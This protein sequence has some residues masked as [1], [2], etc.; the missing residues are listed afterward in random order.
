LLLGI[1]I[2]NELIC[3]NYFAH[4]WPNVNLPFPYASTLTTKATTTIPAL[5]CCKNS[6]SA[7]ALGSSRIYYLAEWFEVVA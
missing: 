3:F 5:Q 6:I 7:F 1:K 2:F 4:F